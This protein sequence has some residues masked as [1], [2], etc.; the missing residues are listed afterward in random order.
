[1]EDVEEMEEEAA[2]ELFERMVGLGKSSD[3]NQITDKLIK[4]FREKTNLSIRKIAAITGLNKDKVNKLL[5][6]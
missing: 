2:K 3:G 5:R 6:S 1:V 4:E